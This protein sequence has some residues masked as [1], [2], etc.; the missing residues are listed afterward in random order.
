[1]ILYEE[2]IKQFLLRKS[3]MPYCLKKGEG[4]IMGMQGY[5]QQREGQKQQVC[6]SRGLLFL[7]IPISYNPPQFNVWT[8][9]TLNWVQ[10]CDLNQCLPLS[11]NGS[12]KVV[13]SVLPYFLM[14]NKVLSSVWTEWDK[15]KKAKT[16]K[17]WWF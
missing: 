3:F 7:G 11:Q 15:K 12:K 6:H 16:L 17:S 13:V 10:A 8:S 4:L 2:W 5:N 9:L 1:M 14:A